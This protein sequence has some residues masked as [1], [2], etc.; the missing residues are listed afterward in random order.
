MAQKQPVD[1]FKRF[2]ACMTLLHG[3]GLS[4]AS[5]AAELGIH[6]RTLYKWLSK[7]RKVGPLALGAME[8]LVAK[9]RA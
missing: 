7:E 3:S 4:F 1:R 2:V 6:E 5:I 8:A 9:K